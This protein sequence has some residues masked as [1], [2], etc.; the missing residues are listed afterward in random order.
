[1]QANRL[2]G[3]PRYTFAGSNLIKVRFYLTQSDTRNSGSF[4]PKL[5]AQISCDVFDVA[6]VS[7]NLHQ[8][9]AKHKVAAWQLLDLGIWRSFD[10]TSASN[11]WNSRVFVTREFSSI[12]SESAI[13]FTSSSNSILSDYKHQTLFGE[14]YST[15]ALT[16]TEKSKSEW[17]SEND[18]A[19]L[20][21]VFN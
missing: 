19:P 11:N 1:M 20:G 14:N 16:V 17:V 3:R 7:L 9:S 15:M 10:P 8:D 6:R 2:T 21:T 4:I 18:L 13:S 12:F 5:T